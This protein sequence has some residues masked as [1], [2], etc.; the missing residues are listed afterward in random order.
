MF[1]QE[2]TMRI[3]TLLTATATVLALSSPLLAG[4]LKKVRKQADFVAMA[5]GHKYYDD[6]GNW[7]MINADGTMTGKWNKK[8]L[9]GAWNWQSR[10]FCRNIVLGGNKL[11]TDCQEMYL[12]DTQL[13]GKRKKGKGD[14]APLMTRK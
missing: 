10:Y 14:W 7:V 8:K 11:P 1:F 9:V 4:D 2:Q 5:A 13:Q 6:K 3:F 12:S